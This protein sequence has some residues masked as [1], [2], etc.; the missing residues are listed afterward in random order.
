MNLRLTAHTRGRAR[1]EGACAFGVRVIVV[2]IVVVM[3]IVIR[4]GG[5]PCCGTGHARGIAV[6]VVAMSVKD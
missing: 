3:I 1:R 6:P 5:I 2:I 4:G